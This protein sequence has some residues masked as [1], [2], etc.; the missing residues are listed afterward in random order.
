MTDTREGVDLSIML[1]QVAFIQDKPLMPILL[2]ILKG[3][4]VR[5]LSRHTLHTLI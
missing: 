2:R 1:V 4:T 5:S 3:I